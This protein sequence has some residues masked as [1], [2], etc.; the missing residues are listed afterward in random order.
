MPVRA[1]RG[2]VLAMF[3]I[4]E[5]KWSGSWRMLPSRYGC[6]TNVARLCDFCPAIFD[7]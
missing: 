2:D 3:R 6:G 1:Q 4:V 7:Q 5:K